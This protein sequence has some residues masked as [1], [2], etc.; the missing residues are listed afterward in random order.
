MQ[1]L[2][3]LVAAIATG[4]TT[5]GPNLL[6]GL[7]GL[8]LILLY[9]SAL[10]ILLA[11][12]NVFLRD[13]QYLVEVVL[14]LL[15]WASPVV[16]AWSFAAEHMPDWAMSIYLSN[17]VTMAVLGFQEALWAPGSAG[18]VPPDLALRMGI[19]AVI[20]VIALFISHRVFARLQG[21]FA[22]EL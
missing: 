22:Q 7:G 3:L 13:V 12:L 11:A 15:M 4:A 16:Y 6:Y 10:G 2:I 9:G 19:A 5:F 21:N 14:L 8:V 20:G 1:L 18:A 17:P